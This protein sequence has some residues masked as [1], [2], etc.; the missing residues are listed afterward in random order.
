MGS[1]VIGQTDLASCWPPLAKSSIMINAFAAIGGGLILLIYGA[2]R[3]V[4]GASATARNL[5]VS[6]L[7]IGLIV[8][9]FATSAPEMLVSGVAAYQGTSSIGIG[10]AIGSNIANIGLVLGVTALL[11]PLTVRSAILRRE[12]PVMFLA[13]V[14]ATALMSDLELSQRDGVIL[15]LSMVLMLAIVV[16]VSARALHADPFLEEIGH[17]PGPQMS[18]LKATLW[19]IVGLALLLIGSHTL[20]WGAVRVATLIGISEVVI[21][22]TII[23]VGTSLPELAASV[24][25]AA[26]GEPEIALGNVIGSNMFNAL[27]VLAAPALIHPAG[28]EREILYRDIPVMFIFTIALF[29]M[30]WAYKRAGRINRIEGLLLLLAFCGYQASLFLGAAMK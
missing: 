14:L 25:S 15:A 9:G 18:Q 23:A 27:G 24:V 4:D 8:I 26:K 17:H 28:F 16:S 10:N 3:V 12:F 29:L 20:I 6:A 2:D 13:L 19:F 30:A 5:G 22:L 11:A 21:G 1:Y 7:V